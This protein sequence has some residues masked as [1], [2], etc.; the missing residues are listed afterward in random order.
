MTKRDD[1]AENKYKRQQ[2]L[3]FRTFTYH[4]VLLLLLCMPS[5]AQGAPNSG[6]R[7]LKIDAG[8]VI[9]QIRSFQGLNGPPSPVMAGLPTLVQQY[10]DLRVDQ[11][12]THDAMGPSEIDSKFVLGNGELA[13]LIPDRAQ[14]AGVVK[15]G[16]AAIIFPDGSADPEKPA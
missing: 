13:W 9:G 2:V 12:R 15:A 7:S 3:A 14:R 10:K 1:R 8:K 6:F 4:G 5:V 16:N 11:I